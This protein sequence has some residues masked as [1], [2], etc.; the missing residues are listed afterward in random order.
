MKHTTNTRNGSQNKPA[1]RPGLALPNRAFRTALGNGSRVIEGVDGRTLIARRYA[2]IAGAI[3]DDLGGEEQL[4]EL[5][6]HLV[7]SVSGMVVLRERLDAEAINGEPVSSSQY[8]RIAN[9]T[10]RVAA[11]LGLQR[12]AKD[13]TSL[14]SILREGLSQ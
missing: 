3:A 5:E 10:R 13:I 14:G 4:T 1:T 7:R 9:A 11:T 8:C 6:K 12:R 2:E